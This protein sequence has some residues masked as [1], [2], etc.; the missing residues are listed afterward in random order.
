MGAG[1]L[2]LHRKQQ[3]RRRQ[4]FLEE[5]LD[6]ETAPPPKPKERRPLADDEAEL[7]MPPK[8]GDRN[9]RRMPKGSNWRTKP[10]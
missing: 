7:S 10:G 1:T 8:R 3:Q 4:Q 5:T 9:Y 6:V 2:N